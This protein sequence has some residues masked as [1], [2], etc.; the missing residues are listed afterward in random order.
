[1]MEFKLVS[2]VLTRTQWTAD[3]YHPTSPPWS[4]GL[5][6]VGI[7]PRGPHMS[8]VRQVLYPHRSLRAAT[9]LL[10]QHL[11]LSMLASSL[12]CR[13]LGLCC[14]SSGMLG[15][16]V[17]AT[18]PL[19]LMGLELY[20]TGWAGRPGN[21]KDPTVVCFPS[22]GMER[23]LYYAWLFKNHSFWESPENVTG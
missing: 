5:V 22:T 8:H 1:M 14:S 11:M 6:V 7:E 2:Q 17:C 21:C 4:L 18:L 10:R 9:I 16:Q 20:C 13:T 15:L 12:I 23:A 19:S 3:K